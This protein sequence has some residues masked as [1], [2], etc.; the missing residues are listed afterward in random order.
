MASHLG[1]QR[2][3][4]IRPDQRQMAIELI[5]IAMA[6]GAPQHKACEV[7]GIDPRTVQRWTKGG[8]EDQR[9]HVEKIPANKLSEQETAAILAMCNTPEFSHKSPHQIVP[10][11]AD[12][13]IYLASERTFYRVLRDADQMARRGRTAS[14]IVRTRPKA[15]TAEQANQV[16]SW[17]ITYLASTVKGIFFYLYLIMDIYSRK[18]VGWEVYEVQSDQRASDV[19]EKARLAEALPAEHPLV[20]HSDN[21]SPMKG[22]TMLSTLERLGVIPSLS[23]PATSN[24]NP[25]SESLFKTLKYGPAYPD[26]PFD[27]LDDARQ[28]VLAF[29]RWYNTEH[30]HSGIKYVTPEQRHLGLDVEILQQRQQVY[31]SARQEHPE[32]WA[33]GIKNW[34]HERQVQLNPDNQNRSKPIP[35]E[36]N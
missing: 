10:L 7:I 34:Q 11:L 3:K 16:G 30:R 32:R 23:R 9:Q 26:K 15:Y 22:A 18:I 8:L 20:L 24:D 2:G 12:R 29:S 21:G 28:W 1:R 19:L 4:L 6:S 35:L 25:Y 27:S 36:K 5:G 31:E 17:D 13:G 14:P 33:G